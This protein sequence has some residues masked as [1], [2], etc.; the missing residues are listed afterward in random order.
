M[1]SLKR[2][3][4]VIFFLK[5]KQT[6]ENFLSD[7]KVR[8]HGILS[9][10]NTNTSLNHFLKRISRMMSLIHINQVVLSSVLFQ[11]TSIGV[12]VGVICNFFFFFF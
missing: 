1:S 7:T 4:L 9:M 10:M 8:K 5:L 2:Q 3:K 6:M 12:A 11:L